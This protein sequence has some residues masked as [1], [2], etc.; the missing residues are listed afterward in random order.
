MGVIEERGGDVVTG[1]LLGSLI[2]APVWLRN[3]FLNF[4][5][6]FYIV[7]NL[8]FSIFQFPSLPF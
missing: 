6:L 3:F 1:R 5:L 8:D 4:L 7:N 2:A